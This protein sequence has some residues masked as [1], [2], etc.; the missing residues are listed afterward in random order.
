MLVNHAY[1][2]ARVF[3]LANGLARASPTHNGRRR[4]TREYP[5]V[6]FIVLT[7]SATITTPRASTF[8][9]EGPPPPPPVLRKYTTDR[10]SFSVSVFQGVRVVRRRPAAAV[11]DATRRR[12]A[13]LLFCHAS[14]RVRSS[15][16]RCL[17]VLVKYSSRYGVR[18]VQNANVLRTRVWTRRR[19]LQRTRFHRT[20]T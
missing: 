2:A 6:L 1:D 15:R 9:F 17:F 19:S 20:V 12:H 10:C 7:S 18:L 5:C 8:L 16:R 4:R 13:L 11:D 3:R 14:R